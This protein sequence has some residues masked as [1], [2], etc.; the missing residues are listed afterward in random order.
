[1]WKIISVL[2]KNLTWSIP[3]F[4]L[5]GILSGYF[6][7]PSILKA[8]IIPFTFLMVY[9]MMVNLKIEELF[10]VG[11]IKLNITAQIINFI[12]IPFVGFGMG[13]LFFPQN[14]VFILGFLITSLLPTSGMTIS[15]TGFAKGDVPAAIKLTVIGLV[16]GSILTPF[17]LQF[18]MGTVIKIPL[19]DVFK[20]IL[21]VVFIPMIAGYATQRFIIQKYGK[22]RYQKDFKPKFPM[23]S[24]VGVLGIVF[25]AMALKSKTI[26]SNPVLLLYI[27][28]PLFLF[29]SFNFI[30]ST[31]IAKALFK[32][33]EAIALV[34]G[35]VMRNLSIALAIAMTA[36]GEKGADIA[37]I[38]AVGYIIQVQAAA[39][40][41]KLNDK[42]F[43]RA[44]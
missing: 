10:S 44:A 19:M 12:I 23:L 8:A 4:M 26:I 43:G 40:Y 36:F 6:Y 16:L 9:P 33:G 22:E 3:L 38:I 32:R 15:W 14:P 7:D 41:V 39:W 20:N 2:Q 29:Y 21:L 34:Y 28:L 5:L 30:F 35:T 24:T 18:L 37:L 13:K 1:M 25:I 42:I 17:Y 31:I 27:F 11:N